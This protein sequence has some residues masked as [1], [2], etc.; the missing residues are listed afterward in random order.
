MLQSHLPVSW[1]VQLHSI[2]EILPA[3]NSFWAMKQE[4]HSALQKQNPHQEQLLCN[5]A[6][7]FGLKKQ[8]N[9]I[10]LWG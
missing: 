6:Q 5:T 9:S 8:L 4:G 1:F 7:I 2:S 10:S 3:T